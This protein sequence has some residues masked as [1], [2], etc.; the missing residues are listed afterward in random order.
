MKEHFP[1]VQSWDR[2][3]LYHGLCDLIVLVHSF[4]QL[5]SVQLKMSVGFSTIL[6]FTNGVCDVP[7][8]FRQQQHYAHTRAKHLPM[9]EINMHVR[10]HTHTHTHTCF[11]LVYVCCVC[12]CVFKGCPFS[13]VFVFIGKKWWKQLKL[14]S[15]CFEPSQLL[16][17]TSLSEIAFFFFKL[18]FFL[19]QRQHMGNLWRMGWIVYGLSR[20]WRYNL[21]LNLLIHQK[22]FPSYSLCCDSP[23]VHV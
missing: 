15:W 22:T 9:G 1:P 8:L 2:H 23:L 5:C 17:V 18:I 12:V 21:E 3:Q 10:T 16:G 14:V 20:A 6:V 4:Q 13:C 11:V 7:K 19:C